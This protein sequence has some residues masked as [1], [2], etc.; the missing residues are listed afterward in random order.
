MFTFPYLKKELHIITQSEA[1][2]VIIKGI[3]EYLLPYFVNTLSSD[4]KKMVSVKLCRNVENLDTYLSK[5]DSSKPQNILEKGG[6]VDVE[7]LTK[8]N[9]EVVKRVWKQGEIS[10]YGDVIII[11][12]HGST[13]VVRISLFGTKIEQISL[14]DAETRRKLKDV[15]KISISRGV[16]IKNN[17]ISDI[18]VCGEEFE[19]LE[20][21]LFYIQKEPSFIHG[22]LIEDISVNL[23]IIDLHIRP[24]PLASYSTLS[25]DVLTQVVKEFVKDKYEILYIDSTRSRYDDW[26]GFVKNM[27]QLVRLS[28]EQISLIPKGYVDEM[29]N[30]VVLTSYEAFGEI[31]L[32]DPVFTNQTETNDRTITEEIVD[33]RINSEEIFKKITPGDYIV[34][35]DHGVGLFNGI[36]D[37]KEGVFL[38]IQYAGKD[39]LFVPLR[40]SN[41]ITKYIGAGRQAKLTTLNNGSWRRVREKADIESEQLAKDLIQIYAVR[42]VNRLEESYSPEVKEKIDTFIDDFQ[43]E[44]TEDQ[45]IV[46]EEILNDLNSSVLMDRLLI[47]DVG[48][49]KTEVAMRAMYASVLMGHQVIFL[50]PT[51]VLVEQHRALL[52]ER[53]EKYG[54]R[55]SAL[56][57][58]F[59]KSE[60]L[61]TIEK[62]KIGELDIIVGTHSLLSKEVAFKDLGLIVI[63]EEQRFGVKQ[64]E[65]LKFK[66]LD[67]HV[68][69]M[70]AT[71]IPRTLNIALAGIRDISIIRTAPLGRKPIIN[72]YGKFDWE[73]VNKAIKFELER[74]GQVYFLHNRVKN[75]EDYAIKLM[76][77]FPNHD[78]EVAHGQLSPQRLSSVIY[79]FGKR[80]I[81]ILVCST[82]IENGIDLPNVNTLIVDKS[83]MFG[84]SQLYQI[85]GRIGRSDKQAYAHFF[86]NNLVGHS[87][88]RL[89]SLSEA[90]KLGSGFIV[91]SKDMEIRGVGE[92]LGK[93]QSGAISAVGYGMFITMLQEKIKALKAK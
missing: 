12:P 40:Q 6:I 58:F 39:R 43:F 79:R 32:S 87:S 68:L 80:E 35:E 22:Q 90:E 1:N 10:V 19:P 55:I 64:K 7:D 76:G 18:I 4:L 26:K 21:E 92:I 5:F 70:S 37:R 3:P 33:R 38:K 85:R 15:D 46:T 17:G 73:N 84:L 65:L 29:N 44:D 57:R 83:E 67:S 25:E 48:F 91:A 14:V 61:A 54:V 2:G 69:S 71:P 9:Y 51:T 77:F 41:K 75:I 42:Q 28:E 63:D 23:P 78:I 53:F 62:L 24:I 13:N 20:I 30:E 72:T 45:V 81:D 89:E 47:G 52:E 16:E 49:G 66:R 50:A 8:K 11:W 93:K 82:I 60:R 27:S 36:V 34:H 88:E 56:S 86:Y 31:N 74:K 59:T